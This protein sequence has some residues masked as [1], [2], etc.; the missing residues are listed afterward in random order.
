MKRRFFIVLLVGQAF[1]LLLFQAC[2]KPDNNKEHKIAVLSPDAGPL[3]EVGDLHRNSIKRA[4][5][6]DKRE[7]TIKV[8]GHTLR[9]LFRGTGN[10]ATDTI[11]CLEK[12][13]NV[14]E[15]EEVIAILGPV[16][17]GCT[18]RI[19]AKNFDVPVISSLSTAKDLI[20]QSDCFFRTIANDKIRLN[21]FRDM[22]QNHGIATN[23]SIAIYDSSSAYGKGLMKHLTDLFPY[24]DSAH[25]FR[26]DETFKVSSHNIALKGY[27]RDKIGH[28]HTINNVF[29]LG[30]SDRMGSYIQALHKLL[31]GK[32]NANKAPNFVLVGAMPYTKNLPEKTWIIGEAQVRT[33]QNLVTA[34]NHQ[35]PDKNLYI[36]TFDAG[37]ALKEAAQM[38]LSQP[39]SD[40][41][42][43]QE[44]RNKLRKVLIEANFASSERGRIVDFNDKGKLLALPKTPIYKV[45]TERHVENV[46]P[47]KPKPWVEIQLLQKPSDHLEGPVTVKLIPHGKGLNDKAVK[48]ELA[49]IREN[50]ITIKKVK[51]KENGT[52]VSFV[53]SFFGQ[54][55]FP[56]AFSI[57]T[58]KTPLKER[59]HIDGMGWPYSYIIVLLSALISTLLYRRYLQQ[60][61][62]AN[63]ITTVKSRSLW[64]YTERCISGLLI[65]FLIIHI[66]PLLENH[67]YLSQIPIPQ[68]GS[69]IWVNAII[70]GIMGGWLGFKPV[71]ALIT[72]I[73]GAL[74]PLLNTEN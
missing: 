9:F 46:N 45:S 13:R 67:P 36:S 54:N 48:V 25:T 68:F 38:V 16:T 73:I 11:S 30:S 61:D 27:F 53:P 41:L 69:S 43:T 52:K 65:A 8:Q 47:D 60:Q 14:V 55:L 34:I 32:Q 72:S 62:R 51:L 15:K 63:N 71:I 20:N 2:N 66:T 64:W 49:G 19:L 3:Q 23:K 4:L 7:Q 1:I 28:H 74:R 26:W 42:T 31:S 44:I 29:V 33:S 39:Q 57:S 40:T 21:A 10:I 59:V 37:I 5:K 17:S 35:N 50:P 18:R 12:A 22:A 6:L 58:D 70:S 24:I 56:N